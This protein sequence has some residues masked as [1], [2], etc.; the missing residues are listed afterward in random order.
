MRSSPRRS[1]GDLMHLPH[2]CTR[3]AFSRTERREIVLADERLSGFLHTRFIERIAH[4]TDAMRCERRSRR[5]V[6][7]EISVAARERAISRM[8]CIRHFA[9]PEC[10]DLRRQ[11]R[12]C[13]EH[14]AALAAHRCRVEVH[15]LH[16]GVNA[17]IGAA[18]GGDFDR[19][20]RDEAE[21]RLDARLNAAC[22]RLGLPSRERAAV[23]FETKGDAHCARLW[24]EDC[25]L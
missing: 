24:T 19:M 1:T 10:T 15:N 22:M 2:R 4:P 6:E 17:G 13:A 23:V 9:R 5:A 11:M 3:L 21:R 25:R 16:R 12:V 8:E 7:N 18:C 14:P 20:I